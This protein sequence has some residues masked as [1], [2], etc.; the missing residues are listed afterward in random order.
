HPS[1]LFS[2]FIY[3]PLTIFSY[4]PSTAR[5]EFLPERPSCICVVHAEQAQDRILGASYMIL[6]KVGSSVLTAAALV[7]MAAGAFA[8]VPM[9]KHVVLVI[10][11][12]TSY[13]DVMA[14]M[15]WLTWQGS[16]HGYAT[17]Y[18]SDN[19]GSLLDYLW[20]ASGSCHSQANCSLPA[21]THNFNC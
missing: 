6:Y 16:N 19:G 8:Q 9:S 2:I 17:N 12:N 4:T 7:C 18:Q 15:P 21:G 20:L 3:Q 10:D 14:N 13:N 1:S 5:N 11:E